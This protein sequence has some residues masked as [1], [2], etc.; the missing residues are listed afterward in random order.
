LKKQKNNGKVEQYINY[1]PIDLLDL[2]DQQ[3]HDLI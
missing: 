2:M 3:I 1:S